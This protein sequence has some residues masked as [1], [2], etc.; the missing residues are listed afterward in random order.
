MVR[1]Q[2]ADLRERSSILLHSPKIGTI[3]EARGA[4]S[5]L[6]NKEV[7]FAPIPVVTDR[8]D[9]TLPSAPLTLS[10]DDLAGVQPNIKDH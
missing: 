9:R 4:V 8:C 10:N 7:L 2:D 3:G 1:G 5:N 6:K